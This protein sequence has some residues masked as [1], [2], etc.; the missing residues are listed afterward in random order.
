MD[1]NYWEKNKTDKGSESGGNDFVFMSS[2][3]SLLILWAGDIDPRLN[4][5]SGMTV[6]K[7][8][9]G[10]F[11]ALAIASMRP[12]SGYAWWVPRIARREVWLEHGEWRGELE[13]VEWKA[14]EDKLVYNLVSPGRNWG[15]Q[16]WRVW[17]RGT[18]SDLHGNETALSAVGR[19]QGAGDW[20][21]RVKC[22]AVTAFQ[23]KPS[24]IT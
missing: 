7:Y 5:M 20:R 3:R 8:G 22:K 23:R 9:E 13:E 21:S 2:V 19:L 12:S 16:S 15:F 18:I 1:V 17:S 6:W 10:S 14:G 4:E 24:W 11:Q